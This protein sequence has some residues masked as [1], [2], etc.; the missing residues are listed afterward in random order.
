MMRCKHR[1][2]LRPTWE[3]KTW[4]SCH[5]SPLEEARLNRPC[6]K[7]ET[8]SLPWFL[9]ELYTGA[10]TVCRN[11]IVFGALKKYNIIIPS[12]II[13]SPLI[14]HLWLA[15]NI[16]I[17][18]CGYLKWYLWTFSLIYEG[19]SNILFFGKIASQPPFRMFLLTE[20]L[21]GM[22]NNMSGTIKDKK[23]S[24]LCLYLLSCHWL[25]CS[26]GKSRSNILW[27]WVS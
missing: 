18:N 26:I 13:K 5:I 10:W 25:I 4:N 14:D 11:L 3:K 21:N 27:L 20:M 24:N 23:T 15:W 8:K 19:L 22:N 12:K 2:P 16:L 9:W 7:N 17:M 6:W 1:N